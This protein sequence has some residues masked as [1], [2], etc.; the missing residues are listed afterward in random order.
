MQLCDLA[1]IY[2]SLSLSLPIAYW[3]IVIQY[4]YNVIQNV[5][6]TLMLCLLQSL[7]SY[8]WYLDNNH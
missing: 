4:H 8:V 5:H 7:L 1:S 6:Y 2:P 3:Y